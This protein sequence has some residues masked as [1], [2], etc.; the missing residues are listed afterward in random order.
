V[1]TAGYGED[2]VPSGDCRTAET[3]AVHP[4]GTYW[5]TDDYDGGGDGYWIHLYVSRPPWSVG[6]L[7]RLLLTV[8]DDIIANVIVADPGLRWL[9]HPY[10]GGMDVLLPSTEERD[11][12]WERHR[13]W[14]PTHGRL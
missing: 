3:V 13:A 5:A 6:A 12:L 1:M 11:A 14:Q 9:Y 7:D 10:D 4:D 2:A 8:A